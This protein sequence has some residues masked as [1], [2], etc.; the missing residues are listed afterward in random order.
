MD[1]SVRDGDIET[2]SPAMKI[3]KVRVI[4]GGGILFA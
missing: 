2:V 3:V 4:E 1:L